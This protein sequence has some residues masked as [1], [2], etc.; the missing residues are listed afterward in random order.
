[1]VDFH[2]LQQTLAAL[3]RPGRGVHIKEIDVNLYLFQLFH[4][5]DINRVCDGSP[6]SF[7]RKALII[8][9]IKIGD[10]PRGVSLNKLDLW[11]QIHDLRPGFMSDKVIQEIRNYI[12]E[13]I[14]SCRNNFTGVWREYMRVPVTVDISKP[15]KR[16]MKMRRAGNEWFWIVF[17]YENVPTFC[18]IC[19]ILGHSEKY[20]SRLFDTPEEE[21]TKPYGAWMRAPFRRQT[22]QIGAQWLRDGSGSSN[23]NTGL[24]GMQNGG[25][26]PQSS[27]QNQESVK[28]GENQGRST[29]HIFD[30]LGNSVSS[31]VQKKQ[32]EPNQSYLIKPGVMIIE[33]KKRRTGQEMDNISNTELDMGFEEDEMDQDTQ[34]NPNTSNDP[35]NDKRAS[36]GDRVRLAL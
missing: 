30:K 27:P 36:S 29:D 4:A 5:I 2:A 7:N 19:G 34:T 16:R 25:T 28:G 1:M 11:V 10:I 14:T 23:R 12:G 17:K 26:G 22:K 35:K 13:F 3:W 21:I 8:S 9:R 31:N 32:L 18:F 20:C 24:N 15:L 33:N 6:W